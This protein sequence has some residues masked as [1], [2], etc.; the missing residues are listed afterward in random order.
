MIY[1]KG[2]DGKPK[3]VS[4]FLTDGELY[5]DKG[6]Q[7]E[8]NEWWDNISAY[9]A[10]TNWQYVFM[11]WKG[12]AIKPPYKLTPTSV[13]NMFYGAAN[14]EVDW[15]MFDFSGCTEVNAIFAASQIKNV[16]WLDFS[17]VLNIYQL[18]KWAGAV[19]TAKI[20]LN[21]NGTKFC[22]QDFYDMGNNLKNLTFTGVFY[23]NVDIHWS[24]RLTKESIQNLISTASSTHNSY[25]ITL[26]KTAVNNAFETSSGLADGSTSQEWLSLVATKSNW[27]ISL[28]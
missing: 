6:K 2:V 22:Q 9:G 1:V 8:N 10:R 19:E 12:K 13:F 28:V 20:H 25:T 14:C 24:S 17:N 4:A 3:T 11:A 18:F 15:D 5:Y 16:G 27:T 7:D 26:S 23:G 21:P